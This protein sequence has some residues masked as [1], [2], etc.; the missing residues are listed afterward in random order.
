[1]ETPQLD[2]RL[3]ILLL[4]PKDPN[5]W[6]TEEKSNAALIATARDAYFDEV[7]SIVNASI[8]AWNR[9]KNH[10]SKQVSHR[11][12]S[13]ICNASDRY[14]VLDT[15][16]LVV[17]RFHCRRPYC[18]F[19]YRRPP[20]TV[21]IPL[22]TT[23]D[24]RADSTADD[25]CADVVVVHR[26]FAILSMQGATSESRKSS[27]ANNSSEMSTRSCVAKLARPC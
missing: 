10:N 19:H 2:A 22:P 13:P 11:L 7:S 8:E 27:R 23:A 14:E 5:S 1:M 18:R 25:R 16:S 17:C 24:D 9:K 20:T 6:K 4:G 3:R 26:A 21:P 12:W 15:T